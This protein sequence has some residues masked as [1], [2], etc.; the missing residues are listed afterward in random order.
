M[1]PRRRRA[2][3]RPGET[4]SKDLADAIAAEGANLLAIEDPI[5]TIE[6]VARIWVALDDALEAI[7]EP[8]LR[9]I[10]TLRAQGWSYDRIA[11]A[12]SLSKA[13]V[14]QLARE[15]RERDEA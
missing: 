7:S 10:A 6:A 15:A 1:P 2:G 12:T 3:Y 14:A 5:A 8:R 4:L 9:A 13:R 11:G